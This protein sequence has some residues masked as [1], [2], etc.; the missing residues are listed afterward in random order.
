MAGGVRTAGRRL[1]RFV[2]LSV[3]DE[4]RVLTALVLLPLVRVALVVAPFAAFRR[5]LLGLAD[6]AV[7]PGTPT[8]ERVAWAVEAADRQLPGHRTC[9]MRSLT[10][11][12]LLRL[13]DL[14]APEHHVGVDPTDETGMKA[15]SWIEH[16]GEVIIGDVE[17][18]SRYEP[19]GRFD[20]GEEQ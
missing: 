9:L 20:E 18:L 14:D 17:D 4:A 5:L 15:H 16:G 11:E 1:R 8:P 2:R 3:G 19:L 12:T 7:V 10:T 6:A 13:Y